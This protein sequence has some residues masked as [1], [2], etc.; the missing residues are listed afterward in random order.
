MEKDKIVRALETFLTHCQ[1]QGA[2]RWLKARQEELGAVPDGD[3]RNRAFAQ[4][5]SRLSPTLAAE[6]IEH[7][8][9]FMQQRKV[10]YESLYSSLL[11]PQLLSLAVPPQRLHKII[12]TLRQRGYKI[13]WWLFTS[14]PPK[15]AL[16]AER[17]QAPT[18]TLGERIALAKKPSPQQ[19]EKLLYDRDES[20][21]GSLLNNPRITEGEVLK[22]ASSNR[23]GP[24]ILQT[25]SQNPRWMNNYRVKLALIQNINTPLGVALGLLNYLLLKDLD[26]VCQSGHLA[27]ELK[28]TAENLLRERLLSMSAEERSALALGASPSLIELLLEYPTP[29]VLLGLLDN[30]HLTAEEVLMMAQDS[31]TPPEILERIGQNFRWVVERSIAL[32]LIKNPQC[33]EGLRQRLSHYLRQTTDN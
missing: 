28:E 18:L 27:K 12:D 11:N 29:L 19:I 14:G 8:R 31:R 17:D 26:E 5:L 23:T 6:V 20:V 21:I 16:P 7:L 10:E 25:I 33:P 15:L 13:S 30:P 3:L 4:E 22:I 2:N 1:A 32:A 9:L 24:G